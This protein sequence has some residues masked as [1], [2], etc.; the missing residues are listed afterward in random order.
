MKPLIILLVLFIAPFGFSQSIQFNVAYQQYPN[1]PKGLLEAVSWSRTHM[2]H[3]DES[4]PESCLEMPR[5]FGFMGLF[6]DG[7]NYFKENAVLVESISG[8]SVTDQKMSAQN[9][10]MAYA[11]AFSTIYSSFITTNSEANSVYLTLDLLSE[12]PDSGSVNNFAKDAQIF[13]VM[14]FMTDQNFAEQHSFSKKHYSLSNVFGA[15]NFQV[16]SS[17]RLEILPSGIQTSNGQSYGQSA[18]K[19]TEYGPAIWNPAPSCNF[20]SRNGVAVSAITIHTIQGSYAGAI[21]WSQNC[22]SNVSFHYVI[23]SS[24]GQITQMVNEANKA[25][26]V[27]SENPY[28]IGY[29]HEGYV[30]DA[31]W[32]TE[33]MYISSADLSRDITNSG[34]GISPLRTFYGAA[35][36]G[37]NTI[38]SCVK[39]KGHQHFP[40]QTHTDPGVNW[41]WEKYYKLINNTPTITTLT[42][43]FD[44]FYD[45]G[46]SSGNYQN[47]ERL[48]WLIAPPAVSNVS[49]NFTSFNTENNFDHLFIYNG[50]TVNSPLIG[51]Y[52]GTTN[53]GLISSTGSSLLVEFR[54]DCSVNSTGWVASYTSTSTVNEPP[55]STINNTNSWRTSDFDV[56]ISDSDAETSVTEKYFLIADR[57]TTDNGWQSNINAGFTYEDFEDNANNWTTINGNYSIQNS[58]FSQGND[59]EGNTNSYLTIAQP[60]GTDYLYSWKQTFLGSLTNQRAGLH[61]MC[62]DATL[63]NRGNSYFIFLR[64]TNDQVHI[65]SVDGDVFTL[66]SNVPFTIDP[67]IT[68]EV[69]TT[70]SPQT[71][72]IKVYI[73]DVFVSSWQDATPLT[74]GNS[75]SLRTGNCEVAFD[76]V[77]VYQSRNSLVSVNTTATGTMRYESV[78]AIATGKIEALSLDAT[79]LWSAISSSEYLIDRSAPSLISIA[80]GTGSDIDT[81]IGNI[82]EGNWDFTDIHSDIANYEYSIGTTVGASDVVSWT[83]NSLATSITEILVSPIYNQLYYLTVRATNGAGLYT[84]NSTDGQL[85]QSP[86]AGI[87]TSSLEAIIIYP[88]PSSDLIY[89]TNVEK[90]FVVIIHDL[91]GKEL[92]SKEITSTENSISLEEFAQGTYNLVLK[93]NGSFQVRQVIKN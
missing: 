75:I 69:K 74:S 78:G 63:S 81:T 86:D 49:L 93:G 22:A 10:L 11:S 55:I 91:N 44:P 45:S 68:Y 72:W 4:T 83:N 8:V 5:A 7:K 41:N 80:D 43:P 90:S 48:L 51:T 18:A 34:Y 92:L 26:H 1:I 87:E 42:N 14:R 23:R 67:L 84:T 52:S 28:T 65:Y 56:Y 31:S 85:I 82:L 16:L 24:D 59:L 73:N 36:V 25:W 57:E 37:T 3:L 61:F 17:S 50:S 20:S 9:Q 39:I 53:P 70:Y 54:S 13:E 64:E 40:S 76:D 33:A 88:N 46:G 12:I 66:Q 47:D 6:E 58:A 62:S 27:G 38:N 21:S 60:F 79:N 77:K 89:F 15:E 35:T 32:Y 2:K 30:D 19:S 29:E 71:G